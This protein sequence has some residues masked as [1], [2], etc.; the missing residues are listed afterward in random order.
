[1]IV[2]FVSADSLKQKPFIERTLGRKIAAFIAVSA[3]VL[4]PTV[5]ISA[6]DLTSET[7]VVEF[8]D[9]GFR[10]KAPMVNEYFEYDKVK[11]LTL[12]PN[13]DKGTRVWGYG[14]PT[15]SSGTFNN[16][17]FGNY[18]LASY[19]EVKPCIFFQYEGKYYAF[20]LSNN[21]DTMK[22]FDQLEMKVKWA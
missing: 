3:I 2:P 21:T 22:A 6:M 1:M 5:G 19:T 18:T 9:D 8:G 10:V 11:D 15:I 4:V 7:V 17:A 16:A 14:T 13:F 20:N 12:D